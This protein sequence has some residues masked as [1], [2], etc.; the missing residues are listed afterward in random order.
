MKNLGEYEVENNILTVGGS[1]LLGSN[2]NFGRKVSSNDIDLLDYDQTVTFFK[3]SR[4]DI[5]INAAAKKV[6]SKLLYEN[7]VDYFDENIRMSLNVFKAAAESNMKQLIVFASINAF[8]DKRSKLVSDSYNHSIKQILS[9]IYYQQYKLNSKVIFLGNVYGPNTKICNGA[10]PM[11]IDKCYKA[12]LNKENLILDGNG[13][14]E[15]EFTFVDDIVSISKQ[16]IGSTNNEPII[17]SSGIVA[18]LY[19]VVAIIVE[20]LEFKGLVQWK[21]DTDKI[22]DKNFN[23]NIV[24]KLETNYKFTSLESGIAKTIN[25]YKANV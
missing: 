10:I 19:K 23:T 21:G 22:V 9:E 13:A 8:L 24:K 15:R 17:I 2:I 25:W 16:F 3:N 1:G 4:A 5:I 18:S 6:S 14:I 12:K 11:I 7:P 20:Q